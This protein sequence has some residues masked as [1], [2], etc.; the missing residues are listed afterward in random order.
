MLKKVEKQQPQDMDKGLKK[1]IKELKDQINN[2]LNDE[3]EK[4]LRL[5]KQ[6]FY[7]SGPK[8]T[9]ILAKRLRTQQIKITLHK[10]RDPI[11]NRITN[12]PDEIH[13]IFQ[14]SNETLYSQPWR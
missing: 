13:K 4:K 10:I 14:N 9:E 1:Q 7:E 6:S 2:I 5:T 3:L 8:A 11:T 12:G